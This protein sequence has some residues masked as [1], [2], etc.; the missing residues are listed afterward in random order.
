M[1][2]FISTPAISLEDPAVLF[3]VLKVESSQLNE[4]VYYTWF[5]LQGEDQND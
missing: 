3:P 2:E 4:E 1:K 5:L